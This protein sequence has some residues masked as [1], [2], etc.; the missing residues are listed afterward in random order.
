M[1]QIPYRDDGPAELVEAIRARRGGTLLNL[2]RMLLNSPAFAQG[3]NVFIGAVRTGLTVPWKLREL[4]MVTVASL[5]R[6]EYEF[7]HHG[8]IFVQAGGT[9][10]QLKA[11][12]DPETALGL[13]DGKDRAVVC[14]AIEMTREIQVSRATHEAL[15]SWFN[16]Q[17]RVELIGVV[18]AYNMVSRF[19]VATGIEV[20]T[21]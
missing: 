18:A 21:A 19:L 2:D 12:R 3:W 20:E 16:D 1:P 4:A 10:E 9:E 11:L 15:K 17:E 5:N 14:L 7:V 6:A 13:F 8:P